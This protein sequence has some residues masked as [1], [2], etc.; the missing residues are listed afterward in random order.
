MLLYSVHAAPGAP[1]AG[2]KSDRPAGE[3]IQFACAGNKNH[4]TFLL[5]IY[6]GSNPRNHQGEAPMRQFTI[7]AATL[8]IAAFVVAAPA[9]ADHVQGGP[10]KQNGQCWKG[11]KGSDTGS[12]GMW[13]ACPEKASTPAAS[14]KRRHHA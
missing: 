11:Q 2:T 12:F 1:L 9:A 3:T 7:A 10:I 4:I 5:L 6:T 14:T 13:T 8:A